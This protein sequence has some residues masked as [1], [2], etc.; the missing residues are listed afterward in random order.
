MAQGAYTLSARR[1]RAVEYLAVRNAVGVFDSS[2]L[3]K[4]RIS[5]PGAER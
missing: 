3:Y 2:P 5:G 4:Y 1:G